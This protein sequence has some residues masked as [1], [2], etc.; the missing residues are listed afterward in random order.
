MNSAE[1]AFG[2]RE[3]LW[4]RF[5][6]WAM[7]G[8][9]RTTGMAVGTLLVTGV[10]AG[11][12]VVSG[13]PAGGGG[14]PTLG[15]AN[16]WVDGAGTCV[17]QPTAGA[18]VDAQACTDLTAAISAA[19]PGDRINVKTGSYA[20]VTINKAVEIHPAPTESFSIAA[21]TMGLSSG[22][23]AIDGGDTLGT[24]ETN[25][26][27]ASDLTFAGSA[28]TASGDPTVDRIIE[29]VRSAPETNVGLQGN[30]SI[31][32]YSEMGPHNPCAGG[33]EDM[34]FG[35]RAGVPGNTDIVQNVQIIGNWLHGHGSNAACGTIHS[36]VCDCQFG[37]SVIAYNR[38][39][40]EPGENGGCS[41]QCVFNASD[42]PAQ[43]AQMINL[44]IIGNFFG[45]SDSVGVQCDGE[46]EIKYNTFGA[47]LN[48]PSRCGPF[49]S[50]TCTYRGNLYLKDP[51]ICNFSNIG[52]GNVT[53][54]YDVFPTS[55]SVTVPSADCGLNSIK[56]N[57]TVT[58]TGASAGTV[59]A[60]ASAIEGR[61]DPAFCPPFDINL[62]VRPQGSSAVCDVGAYE[63]AG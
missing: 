9:G 54:N 41:T 23:A 14:G 43:A 28:P 26:I 18:Y 62:A 31:Y 47:N 57:V 6:L 42:S 22:G 56:A 36:D 7:G 12:L 48:P 4:H 25:R 50:S 33:P 2:F 46:C 59:T 5:I 40:Q 55:A 60:N 13:I 37:N 32:R 15:T 51:S 38:I 21:I 16:V 49:V 27:T 3:P 30:H 19:S 53:H 1:A 35:G 10:V 63:T 61:G 34:W 8:M 44:D 17:R 29:D 11:V 24:N 39:T 58:A 52:P 20:G 45:V